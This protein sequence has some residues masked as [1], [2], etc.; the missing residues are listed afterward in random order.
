MP[1]L[2][3]W[4]CPF[5]FGRFFIKLVLFFT[6]FFLI[7][8]I[9][10]FQGYKYLESSFEDAIAESCENIS[11]VAA[12]SLDR[13]FLEIYQSNYLV[14]LDPTVK[15][16]FSSNNRIEGLNDYAK[17]PQGIRSLS[18]VPAI[19]DYIENV[20]V[21]KRD[22]GV[23]ISDKAFYSEG[24]Y[25][26]NYHA[27]D[28]YDLEY[29]QNYSSSVP[30]RILSPC[31]VTSPGGFVWVLPIV[32]TK[33]FN[34]SSKNL[35]VIDLNLEKVQQILDAYRVTDNSRL[36][37]VN[38]EQELLFST[39]E[40]NDSDTLVAILKNTKN[41]L[42]LS[43]G[44]LALKN[45]A[46]FFFQDVEIITL[47]PKSDITAMIGAQHNQHIIINLLSFLLAGVLIVLF[48]RKAYEP[49]KLLLASLDPSRD[50]PDE[51]K[52]TDEFD[53]ILG[54]IGSIRENLQQTENELSYAS[55]LAEE[56]LLRKCLLG[57]GL[58][59]EEQTHLES[60]FPPLQ[61][62]RYQAVVIKFLFKKALYS[63][64]DPSFLEDLHDTL[65]SVILAQFASHA[66][67]RIVE[68]DQ[69]RLCVLVSGQGESTRASVRTCTDA[70]IHLFEGDRDYLSIFISIGH[71][72]ESLG[73]VS[74]SYQKADRVLSLASPFSPSCVFD[75]EHGNE[76]SE[77]EID[78]QLESKLL[79]LI[80]V[81]KR[82]SLFA[83]L[84]EIIE[85]SRLQH[86]TGD[87]LQRL[88]MRLYSIATKA[89]R[90]KERTLDKSVYE[91][92]AAF[93]LSMGDK[94]PEDIAEFLRGFFSDVID[95]YQNTPLT[96]SSKLFKSY[97]DENYHQDL[98]LD[99][100][101][102][103]YNTSAQYISRL[104]KKEL[105][106][107]FA[108]Y[109]NQL[110]VA[111]AKDLLENTALSITEIYGKVGYNSR[112]TFIRAFKS[113][114]GITPSDYRSLH[115]HEKADPENALPLDE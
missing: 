90:Q 63:S 16:I 84:Q 76:Y 17:I 100:L 48:S 10:N 51:K 36:Y 64:F 88:L 8:Q 47:I 50:S 42:T 58:T 53:Y 6:A 115:R 55:R 111:K 70:L 57:Q 26:G 99:F 61:G 101:A 110:R 34:M 62:W 5:P 71:P 9:V 86:L 75:S 60:F 98:S 56:Q 89:L 29:W 95:C 93:T 1:S 19:S 21:Y 45:R 96:L 12:M 25:Y 41:R 18:K 102:Q 24:D 22:S 73:D 68:T 103:K 80:C 108:A 114:E 14:G 31:K 23:V 54:R 92:F 4:F 20:C 59:A 87:A 11:Q 78:E 74:D 27:Y 91:K 107:P 72:C 104:L 81:G 65:K 2:K 28:R 106:M 32:Q 35:Y 67:L 15:E 112:Y 44:S 52:Q 38:E 77:F 13:I 43:D 66:E 39:A 83:L 105:G 113:L 97:L 33:V 40:L 85:K 7:I 37:V 46:N 109:L 30:F 82:E 94:S 79:N 69:N 3:K 49:L